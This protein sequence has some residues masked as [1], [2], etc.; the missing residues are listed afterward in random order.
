ME[1]E[2]DDY[3]N[4]IVFENNSLDLDELV[5]EEIQLFLPAKMLC[6]EDCR[7][8]CQKCGKNL[9]YEKCECAKEIDPRL[10]ALSDLLIDE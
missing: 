5:G 4:Y 10:A 9:N 7:G 3:D 8:L 6:K 2:N 1:N